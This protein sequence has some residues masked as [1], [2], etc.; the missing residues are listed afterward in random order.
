MLKNY[1][2]PTQQNNNKPYLLR[3]I[4]IVAYSLLLILTNIMGGILGIDEAYA[5]T[6]TPANII[7][8]TNQERK[9][10]G[11]G[12]L[13]NNPQLAN[14]ALA[15]ANDMI[16]KQYWDHF[17]P[18]GETPWQF[19]R[20][21]G[22]TY[23]YAGENLAK[24]F[25]TSEGVV[26]AWMASPTHKANIM[27]ANYRD[28]GIAVVEGEL[29][30][31]QT[32][33]V[34]Q[35]FGNLTTSVQ[36]TVEQPPSVVEEESKTPPKVVT[37]EDKV[38]SPKEQG[39][40]RS[41][42]ITTPSN[43]TT[44]MEPGMNV[45]GES[46][47]ITGEYIV[48][49]LEGERL[50]GSTKSNTN[51]WEVEKQ[52]DWSEG[53]HKIIANLNGTEIKSSEVSFSIDSTPPKVDIQTV[54]VQEGEQ[55]YTLSFSIEGEWD[56]INIILGAEILSVEIPKG[57]QSIIT[58]IPK[59]YDVSSVH[60]NLAD[61]VGNSS[62]IDISE[63]FVREEEKEESKKSIIPLIGLSV[64]DGISIGVVLF[65]FILLMIEVFVLARKGQLK[66]ASG[67]LF[68]IGAWW[69]V[70]SVAIFNGFSGIIT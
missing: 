5:S 36:G 30:G 49:V 27:S 23:V 22:Y 53:D 43:G 20:S 40:I 1:F 19:I 42:Q 14:A 48:N 31:K 51:T 60:I 9:A 47:N 66:T 24:G 7:S 44:Y 65:V 16:E 70:I 56:N 26:E 67:E 29:L 62:S 39:E 6:I 46:S 50:V 41:I 2:I 13:S 8:L 12:S 18:N 68:T 52:G 3:K 58:S 11:L 54:R 57:E 21:A 15:K 25:R 10:S 64:K 63:Y 37:G 4:A 61:R 59:K 45:K 69:L 38:I 33:L 17:G 28:I 35:M 34:V 32:L 55:E